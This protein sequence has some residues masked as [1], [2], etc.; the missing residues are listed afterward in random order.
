MHHFGHFQPPA[1]I[2]YAKRPEQF[3]VKI[4]GGGS[5]LVDPYRQRFPGQR[6]ANLDRDTYPAG[7]HLFE[8]FKG[9]PPSG[10][11]GWY[12]SGCHQRRP[13]PNWGCYL[14]A[15]ATLC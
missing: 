2:Q 15:T 8:A 13:R 3:S 6:G 4:N 11:H 9:Y 12:P 10:E 5:A 1:G 7:L 14:P